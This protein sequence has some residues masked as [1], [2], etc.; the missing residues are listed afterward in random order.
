MGNKNDMMDA[1]AIWMAQYSSQVKMLPW[2]Q[3]RLV[4]EGKSARWG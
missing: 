1:R 4:Q 2:C 3:N